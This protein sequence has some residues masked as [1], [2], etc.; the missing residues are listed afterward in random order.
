[1]QPTAPNPAAVLEKAIADKLAVSIIATDGSE[2]RPVA[3]QFIGPGRPGDPGA[4]WLQ[5][6]SRSVPAVKAWS[7]AHTRVSVRFNAGG[8]GAGCETTVVKHIL[9]YWLT[10]R[11][12]ISSMLHGRADQDLARAAQLPRYQLRNDGGGIRAKL[13]RRRP[14]TPPGS[15]LASFPTPGLESRATLWDIGLGGVGFICPFGRPQSLEGALYEVT[16]QFGGKQ[17]VYPV[18]M[19]HVRTQGNLLRVGVEVAHAAASPEANQFLKAVI[20][21]LE[22]RAARWERRSA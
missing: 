6:A 9:D 4:M 3:A 21:D 11:L 10:E 8:T 19:A 14:P 16:L 12:A 15:P 2:P 18:R 22:Q 7:A 5:P 13:S 17:A 1:M 20:A